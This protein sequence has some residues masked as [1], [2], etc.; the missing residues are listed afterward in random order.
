MV[1]NI[2]FKQYGNPHQS[3]Q[4]A[5][6]LHDVRKGTKTGRQYVQYF[7]SQHSC[8]HADDKPTPYMVVEYFNTWL[9]STRLREQLHL[10]KFNE[11]YP[12]RDHAMDVLAANFQPL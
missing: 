12:C 8:I 9:N 10:G 5:L 11:Y 7:D 3:R 2:L 1:K 4:Y 6:R